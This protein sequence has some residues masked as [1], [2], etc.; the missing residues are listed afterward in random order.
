MLRAV[1][2]LGSLLLGAA[3]GAEGECRP[4]FVGDK[5]RAREGEN[6]LG[7]GRGRAGERPGAAGAARAAR[8]ARLVSPQ[9]ASAATARP[10]A[11]AGKWPPAAPRASTG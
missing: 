2:L 11:A 5:G 7:E 10:T 8:K 4:A 3:R 1:L 9:S 6:P